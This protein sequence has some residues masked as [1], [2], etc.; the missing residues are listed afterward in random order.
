MRRACRD[1]FARERILERIVR[2]IDHVLQV[3][4]V[5]EDDPGLDFDADPARPGDLW[6]PDAGAVEGGVAYGGGDEEEAPQP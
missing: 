6:D 4:P 2:D 3:P 1:A 5:S